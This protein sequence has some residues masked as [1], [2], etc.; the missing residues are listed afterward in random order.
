VDEAVKKS[1]EYK[2][3]LG[4]ELKEAIRL[5]YVGMTRAR[6]YLFFAVGVKDK[7]NDK[8][9][10]LTNWLDLLKDKDENKLL[11]LPQA[12]GP[13]SLSIGNESFDIMV[14]QF[15]PIQSQVNTQAEQTY[16]TPTIYNSGTFLP[17]RL[18][19]SQQGGVITPT[20]SITNKINLGSRIALSGNPDMDLVGNAIHSFLA[21]DNHTWDNGRRLA[22]AVQILDNWKVTA[23]T[24]E[25]LVKVSDRLRSYIEQTYGDGCDWHREWPIHLR[26]GD[27]KANGWIDLLLETPSGFVIIDHK[28]FP[29]SMDKWGDKAIGYAPQLALYR[30][31]VEKATEKSVIAT[32]IHMPVLGVMLEL[33]I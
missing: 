23:I 14:E 19:P 17:A 15:Y 26:K 8:G 30:E 10:N 27:Q 9:K 7:G 29:G 33:K 21:V 4:L 1:P 22:M 5:L 12:V 32:M 2:E 16:V 24:A 31:A 25:S 28:S 6:D 18:V 11:S 3:V 13:Q 20:V